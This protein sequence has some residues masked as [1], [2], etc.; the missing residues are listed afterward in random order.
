MNYNFEEQMNKTKEF[1]QKYWIP[2]V[3]AIIALAV[4][5]SLVNIY[6]EQVLDLDSD[7]KYEK[8]NTISKTKLYKNQK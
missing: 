5:I 2:I 3:G 4:I 1:L 8:Q 7:V 6:K